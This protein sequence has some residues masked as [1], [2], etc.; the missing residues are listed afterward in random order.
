VI[1]WRHQTSPTLPVPTLCHWRGVSR[2]WS[3]AHPVGAGPAQEEIALR[4]AIARIV[5]DFAGS[6]YRRV[7]PALRRAGWGPIN[8]QR[9]LRVMREE[10]LRCQLK[11]RFVVT[12]DSAH[13][14][15]TYPHPAQG[16]HS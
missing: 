2:S 6:G 8:H 15:R 3:D 5:L 12:T 9:V 1:T 7:T 4:D 10:S 13:G 16:R 14:S 11:R